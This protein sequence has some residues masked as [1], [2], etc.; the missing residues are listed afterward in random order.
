MNGHSVRVMEYAVEAGRELGLSGESLETLRLAG[1]LH[2]IGKLYTSP[3]V[4]EKRGGLT[5]KE[6]EIV[7][8]HPAR[9]ADLLLQAEALPRVAGIIRHH[10]ERFDGTGY[11]DGLAGDAIPFLS[12]ILYVADAFDSMTADR[13]YRKAPGKDYAI[14]ELRRCSGTQFD[15]MVVEAFLKIL[16]ESF[17]PHLTARPFWPKVS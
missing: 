3:L 16:R 17:Q 2:D 1:L 13:P 15:P 9:G 5:S 12:R 6:F 14:S 11:P 10:H 4:L 8:L 7:K